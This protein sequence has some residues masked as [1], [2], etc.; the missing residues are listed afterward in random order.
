MAF[1][2]SLCAL[3]RALRWAQ[4]FKFEEV[5]NLIFEVYDVDTAYNSSDATHIDPSKQVTVPFLV[6]YFTSPLLFVP[7][8]DTR[9]TM[10]HMLV[11]N[12][13]M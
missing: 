6:S 11:E 7:F 13:V 3:R 1:H 5:Q 4:T 10:A 12:A 2:L 9:Q 8:F